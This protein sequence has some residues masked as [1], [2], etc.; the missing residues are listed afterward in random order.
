MCGTYDVFF[1]FWHFVELISWVGLT[2]IFNFTCSIDKVLC[3]AS[4]K[5]AS[6]TLDQIVTFSSH[7]WGNTYEIFS[8]SA[9]FGSFLLCVVLKGGSLWMCQTIGWIISAN[10]GF[11]LL[12]LGRS[13]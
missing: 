4:Y 10:R 13:K 3:L 12:V 8:I 1:A 7:L 11:M 2:S 9:L 6:A 5:K